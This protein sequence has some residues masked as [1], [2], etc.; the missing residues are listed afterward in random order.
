MNR[1]IRIL[2]FLTAVVFCVV[3][4]LPL[5]A[6]SPQPEEIKKAALESWTRYAKFISRCEGKCTQHSIE[7]DENGSASEDETYFSEAICKYPFYVNIG[8]SVDDESVNVYGVNKSYMFWIDRKKEGEPWED[9]AAL[10]VKNHKKIY[11]WRYLDSWY[12]ADDIQV[13]RR[14]MNILKRFAPQMDAMMMPL[15]VLFADSNFEITE[16]EEITENETRKIVLSF[17][18]DPGFLSG[19]SSA[20]EGTITLLPDHEW[21][22]DSMELFLVKVPE[23]PDDDAPVEYEFRVLYRFEYDCQYQMPVVAKSLNE[24]YNIA[25][26]QMTRKQTA[27]YDIKPIGRF[28][29]S[30][31]RFTFSH[32]GLP[33]PDFAPRPWLKYLFIAVGAVIILA[34]M[35]RKLKGRKD[36]V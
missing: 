1:K 20:H 15:P 28:K 22:V 12:K 17:E 25:T 24:R 30:A 10:P 5:Y 34:V 2:S 14:D 6:D 8:G 26:G 16:S 3:F 13:D 35:W 4:R 32:Y 7:Y 19:F 11:D 18:Y 33:E 36:S 21:M 29:Y 23:E 9:T 27:D 31:R